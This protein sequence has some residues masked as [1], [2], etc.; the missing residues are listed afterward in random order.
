VALWATVVRPSAYEVRGVLV[1]RPA[2]DMIVVRHDAVSALGM[3]PMDLMAIAAD[4]AILDAAAVEPGDAVRLAVRSR[5][6]GI[7]LLR[8]EKRR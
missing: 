2:P 5:D 1:A 7:V 3:A 8:I 6:A 4:P